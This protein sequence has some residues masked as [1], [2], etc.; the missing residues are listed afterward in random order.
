MR[1][2]GRVALVTGTS[3]N[4]GGGIAEKFLAAGALRYGAI[5]SSRRPRG[6]IDV[7]ERSRCL[8][9]SN[10]SA[11]ISDQQQTRHL[12]RASQRFSYGRPQ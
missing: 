5:I 2:A 9:G 6:M 3:P 8:D 12:R 11:G 10:V 4:I 7:L 1:L